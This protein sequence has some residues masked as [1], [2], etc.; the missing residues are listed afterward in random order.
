VRIL[1]V[2]LI[3]LGIWTVAGLIALWPGNASAHIAKDGSGYSAPGVSYPTARITTITET[4]CEGESGS[5]AGATN[6]TCATVAGELL[7]GPEK[8]QIVQVPLN[9]AVYASGIS[10]G[11]KVK[12]VRLPPV[13]NQS[14]QYQ[15][16]DFDRGSALVVLGLLLAVTVMVVARWKGFRSLLGLAASGFILVKFIF[17]ALIS[18]TNPILVGLIGSAA[19][20]FVLLFTA[21]GF[22]VSTSTAVVGALFALVVIAGLGFA[23][24][25]WAHLTGVTSED[26]YVL[27]A[28]LPDMRLT[29]VVICAVIVAGLGVLSDVAI[30]QAKAVW[31]LADANP[32]QRKLFWSAMRAGRDHIAPSVYSISF[33]T[34][35]AA[36]PVLLLLAVYD[37][38]LLQVL[39]TEQFAGE[40]VRIMVVA[41]GLVLAA[42]LT[43]AVGVAV[44]RISG[45][46]VQP[47][48]GKKPKPGKDDPADT[49]AD[50]PH[51]R[52]RRRNRDD[53]DDDFSDLRDPVDE[54][55]TKI[56]RRR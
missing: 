47:A 7:E 20:M 22:T 11:Q 26:D 52:R 27:A 54:D 43:A 16:S 17:P 30:S 12:L 33:A 6:Q 42:P 31:G 56:I 9:N 36:L 35:G 39:Q 4:S 1:V 14:A 34:V 10:I 29:S 45:R 51:Q 49:A 3:P 15:F 18:G 23:A 38:P 55:D 8:G 44:A 41:I 50:S 37:R 19:I 21:H 5:T 48:K 24:T 53:F 13:D 25:K 32:T 28:T 46:T 2:V 40:L